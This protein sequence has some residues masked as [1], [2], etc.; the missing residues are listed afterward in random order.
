MS[1]FTRDPKYYVD[2]LVYEAL[3]SKWSR[4]HARCDC[5]NDWITHHALPA[6]FTVVREGAGFVALVGPDLTENVD[7]TRLTTNAL[8]EAV[9]GEPGTQG[10]FEPA[11]VIDRG[12]QAEAERKAENDRL[13]RPPRRQRAAAAKSEPITEAQLRY[14]TTLVTKASKERF[15]AEFA[16]AIKGTTIAARTPEEKTM[17][18]VKRLSKGAARKLITGLL[19]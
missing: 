14:L 18:A 11:I 1:G 16:A 7:E 4:Y 10:W 9:T 19:A 3:R 13:Y 6:G 8:W 2:R 12:E 5:G 15:D 17:Y